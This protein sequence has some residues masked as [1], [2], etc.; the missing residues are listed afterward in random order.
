LKFKIQESNS[1]SMEDNELALSISFIDAKIILD[2]KNTR[3]KQFK[4][5]NGVSSSKL[6][7][8]METGKPIDIPKI[9]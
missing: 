2:L 8:N 7:I 5:K 3:P 4:G 9:D 1:N 6:N